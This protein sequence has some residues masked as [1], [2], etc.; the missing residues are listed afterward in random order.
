MSKQ[1]TRPSMG[2]KVN[3]PKCGKP[4]VVEGADGW[5]RWIVCEACP[6]L[7]IV[8][9][10]APDEAAQLVEDVTY[11]VDSPRSPSC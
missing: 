7:T 8:S 4:C 10:V 5:S 1:K 3:C 2:L 9:S 6:Q 11:G